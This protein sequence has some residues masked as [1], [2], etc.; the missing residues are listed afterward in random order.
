MHGTQFLHP[1]LLRE[2]LREH[3]EIVEAMLPDASLGRRRVAAFRD[4]R[5]LRNSSF[6]PSGL[7]H[8][9]PIPRA[10]ALGCIF[11]PLRGYCLCVSLHPQE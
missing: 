2:P 3:H 11:S 5:L 1:L 4:L 6:A 10:Y 9:P 8:F 7:A